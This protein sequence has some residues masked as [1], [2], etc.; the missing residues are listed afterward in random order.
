EIVAYMHSAR[1]LLG[2][3]PNQS[4]AITGQQAE[5]TGMAPKT[6]IPAPNPQAPRRHENVVHPTK[7]PGDYE[8]YRAT[9]TSSGPQPTRDEAEPTTST[10]PAFQPAAGAD[11]PN[12]ATQTVPSPRSQSKKPPKVTSGAP[13][14][15]ADGEDKGNR[16]LPDATDYFPPAIA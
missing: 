7:L 16:V 13:V 12:R 15:R 11:A 10:T 8:P 14:T 6:P 3:A 9:E 4:L 5:T 1:Q 2:G